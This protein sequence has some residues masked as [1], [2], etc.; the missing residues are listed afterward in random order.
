MLENSEMMY[1]FKKRKFFYQT[2]SSTSD[3][4]SHCQGTVDSSCTRV[5]GT[6]HGTGGTMDGCLLSFFFICNLFPFRLVF[7]I[8]LNDPNYHLQ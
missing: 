7:P 2:S 6:N 5:N 1:P 4:W 3:N 8:W